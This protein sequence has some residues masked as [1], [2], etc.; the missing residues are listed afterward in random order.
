MRWRSVV[1]IPNNKNGNSDAVF[2]LKRKKRL[3]NIA[4]RWTL[5]N[6]NNLKINKH[7]N[8]NGR[9]KLKEKII[10]KEKKRLIRKKIK[11]IVAAE[12]D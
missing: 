5:K 12:K 1:E 11:K 9:K 10:I 2:N 3:K 6:E 8:N 7:I 4:K